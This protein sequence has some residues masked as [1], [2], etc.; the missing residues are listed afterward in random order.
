MMKSDRAGFLKKNLGVEI[1]GKR[2]S[3]MRFFEIFS[4]TA[5]QISLFFLQKE[6]I[7]ILHMCAKRQVQE[8]SGSPDMGQKGGQK[9]GIRDFLKN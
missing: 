9:W 7:I 8:K 5:P 4:E 2:G 1:L 3:K 6:N